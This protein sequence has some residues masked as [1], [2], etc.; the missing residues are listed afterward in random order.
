MKAILKFL[1]KSFVAIAVS[2]V[3]GLLFSSLVLMNSALFGLA[4]GALVRIGVDTAS[5]ALERQIRVEAVQ[6]ARLAKRKAAGEIKEKAIRKAKLSATRNIAA[7]P[8]ESLPFIGVATIVGV[9][10]WEIKDLCEI[11]VFIDDLS[12]LYDSETASD[13]TTEL[14]KSIQE[15]VSEMSEK[16]P[17]NDTSAPLDGRGMPQPTHPPLDPSGTSP[18]QGMYE[19]SVKVMSEYFENA[20][21]FYGWDQTK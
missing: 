17:L 19:E 3:F 2:A 8:L 10:A 18:V 11:M 20:A 15:E 5:S 7:M 6:E 1:I 13:E 21:K 4:N 14:C 9:T 12:T 16:L